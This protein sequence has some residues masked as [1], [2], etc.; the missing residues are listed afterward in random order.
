MWWN[1]IFQVSGG[2]WKERLDLLPDAQSLQLHG[3]LL[4]HWHHLL[5]PDACET[6]FFCLL[7]TLLKLSVDMFPS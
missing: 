5:L 6:K 4:G 1:V 2:A 3:L 7:N